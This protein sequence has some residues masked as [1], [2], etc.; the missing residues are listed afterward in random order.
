MLFRNNFIL[1]GAI[2]FIALLPNKNMAKDRLHKWE[3]VR[4]D[5]TVRYDPKLYN[6]KTIERTSL[7]FDQGESSLHPDPPVV[8]YPRHLLP[9]HL[10]RIVIDMYEDECER[11]LRDIRRHKLLSFPV[12]EEYRR[13]KAEALRNACSFHVIRLQGHSDPSALRKYAPSQAVCSRHIDALE[14]KHDLKMHWREVVYENCMRN[15]DPQGCIEERL[16]E[17]RAPDADARIRIFVTEFGWKNCSVHHLK[18]NAIDF[19]DMRKRFYAQLRQKFKMK[20][21]CD[22]Y[23]DMF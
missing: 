13:A 11:A 23:N 9:R 21:Q 6:S 1:G 20:L 5:H 22:H 4:C 19:D 18:P 3:T 12:V 16:A 7:F 10:A 14:G 8:L 15:G 17:E 2:I